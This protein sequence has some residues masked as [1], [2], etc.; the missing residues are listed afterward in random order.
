MFESLII[1]ELAHAYVSQ[2]TDG[3]AVSRLGHEYLAYALQLDGLPAIER[4]RIIEEA[5]VEGPVALGDFSEALLSFS[6]IRFAAMAWMHFKG[7]PDPAAAVADI[8]A[9]RTLFQSLRE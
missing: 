4:E 9:G 6:P 2:S 1:H 5:G 8:L 3:H 7:R